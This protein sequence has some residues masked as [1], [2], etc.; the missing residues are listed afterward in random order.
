MNANALY[1]GTKLTVHNFPVYNLGTK[2]VVCYVWHEGEGVLSANEFAS[3]VIDY[4][5]HKTNS[6]KVIIFSD[7]CI[8]QNKKCHVGKCYQ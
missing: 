6:K 3:C 5:E 4:L 1:Y 8:Y 2:D 7:G